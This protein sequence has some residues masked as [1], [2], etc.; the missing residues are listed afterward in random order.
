MVAEIPHRR[1]KSAKEL[2][3]K[4]GVTPRTIKNYMAEPREVFLAKAEATRHEAVKLFIKG[5]SLK[6][7]AEILDVSYS[8]AALYIQR[9]KKEGRLKVTYELVDD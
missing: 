5:H 3:A 7:I 8:S 4:L 9:A 6:E 2:A 1:P